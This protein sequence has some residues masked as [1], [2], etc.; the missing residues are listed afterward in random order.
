MIQLLKVKIV[1]IQ[2]MYRINAR[3]NMPVAFES[4]IHILYNFPVTDFPELIE[5]VDL[6]SIWHI[7]HTWFEPW[8]AVIKLNTLFE[9]VLRLCRMEKQAVFFNT[10]ILRSRKEGK[11]R[12][13]CSI[14]SRKNVNVL[15]SFS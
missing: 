12:F 15:Y 1:S 9:Q 5:S 7:A 11:P 13:C 10:A 4:K 14:Y 6:S 3:K 8:D 2:K